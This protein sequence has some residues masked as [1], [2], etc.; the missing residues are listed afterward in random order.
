[1]DKIKIFIADDH[2][3][4][5]QGIAGTILEEP[6]FEISGEAESINELLSSKQLTDSD[7]LTLD[8]SFGDKSS[9]TI[10][11]QLFVI[12][13]E[14]KILILSMH[15]K[16]VLIKRVLNL[17]AA[18]YFLKSSPATQLIQA[19]KD[20]NEG[21]KYLDPALSDSI[22]TLLNDTETTTDTYSL[23]NS[24]S[25]REQEIFRLL[26]EG[27]APAGIARK[28]NISR[29][30]VENHRSNIQHKLKLSSPI[31]LI[32]LAEKLGVV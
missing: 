14:L 13:P 19:V 22:F 24:L 11:P 31:E 5:R 30:T 3:L 4:F 28:L 21:R 7:I 23:Y 2:A 18:G 29:K 1:M 16:P 15:D 17:G 9:L 27:I 25:N 32:Q 6:T 26:A 10:I 20:I 12:N 8:I